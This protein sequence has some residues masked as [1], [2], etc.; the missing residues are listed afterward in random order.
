MF[1]PVCESFCSR[2]VCVAGR[3]ACM[4]RGGGM[5]A[6][7]ERRPLQRTV[8]MLLECILVWG[9]KGLVPPSVFQHHAVGLSVDPPPGVNHSVS[10]HCRCVWK[11]LKWPLVCRLS[12]RNCFI[13]VH[14]SQR[15]G[16]YHIQ[17]V[18]SNWFLQANITVNCRLGKKYA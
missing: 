2:G 7:Q 18:L 17:V 10:S 15:T 5:G 14:S 13:A 3:G 8:R 6:W 1:T 9:W 4:E 16:Y 12:I 11:S